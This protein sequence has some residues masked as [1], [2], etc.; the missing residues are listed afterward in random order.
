MDYNPVNVNLDKTLIQ[1]DYMQIDIGAY[2]KWVIEYGYTFGDPKKVLARVTEPDLQYGSDEDAGGIDATVRRY[3]LAADPLD[4]AKARFELARVTR[5]RILEK[6]VKDGQSWSKA[7]RGYSISLGMQMDAIS[8]MSNWVGAARVYRDR[9]GDP[10][11]RPPIDVVSPEQQRAALKFVIETAFNDESFGLT[12][13]LL[14]YFTID[15]S[16]DP[17]AG[18]GEP[19]WPIHDQVAGVQASAL[20]QLINPERMRRVYDN[21]FRVAAD[22]DAL[23][24]AE[25]MDTI[26]GAVFREIEAPR[27]GSFTNRQPMVSSLRRNLQRE[28]IDRLIDLT[29][30]GTLGG[31]ASKPVANLATA[32]LRELKAKLEAVKGADAYT[33]AHVGEA[34]IRIGKALDAQYIYNTDRIG[35]GGA[36]GGFFF[37]QPAALPAGQPTGTVE[38]R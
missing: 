3:D 25:V 8:I 9:K 21:E 15:R 10:N 23:T 38:E 36:F 7:R 26:I 5:G 2:D 29:L 37:G 17:G 30:P 24:L 16:E 33:M 34:A 13:E 19:A 22:K 31:E 11:G 14:R 32:K 20:T 27:S 12:P 28:C 4:Y 18:R 35:G 6:F 1:G